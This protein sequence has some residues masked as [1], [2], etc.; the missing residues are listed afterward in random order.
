[1]K[2]SPH[3]FKT[4][5][6][7]SKLTL[8][9]RDRY[10][11]LI[12]GYPPFSEFSFP[13]L[14]TWWNTLNSCAISQLN[15]NLVISHWLPG[16]EAMSGLSMIGTDRVDESVC[17]IFDE[18]K[19]HSEVARLVH[20]PEFVVSN[21]RFPELYTFTAERE[22]DECVIPVSTLY[23]LGNM[24]KHRRWKVRRFL[25]EVEED[26]VVLKS[27]DFKENQQEL[28]DIVAAWQQKGTRNNLGRFERE[29]IETAIIHGDALGLENACVYIDG[30]MHSFLLYSLPS[31][32]EYATIHYSRFSFAMPHIFEFVAYKYAHWFAD[33]G[34]K[35]VNIE[36]DLGLPTLRAAKLALGP[37]NF[38]RKYTI[39]PAL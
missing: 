18:L 29:A 37:S 11:A 27:L 16:D 17:A 35:Y 20:V 4:F 32:A 2:V 26:R 36:S 19:G 8:A 14:M 25:A 15:G 13:T 10:Q 30:Q 6:E 5:P 1:M 34:V 24:I 12:A 33:L 39:K 22:L 28:L 7:F 23:S 38:F 3:V 9:D 31:E 21:M